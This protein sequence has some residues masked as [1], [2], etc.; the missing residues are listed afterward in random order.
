MQ[1]MRTT[2]TSFAGFLFRN[3]EG[4]RLWVGIAAV[5]TIIQVGS[6]LALAFPFKIILDKVVSHTNPTIPL[7]EGILSFFDQFGSTKNLQLGEVHT[8]LG[9]ILFSLCLLVI[10]S[11]INAVTTYIQNSIASIVGKNLTAELRKK[12]FDQLQ[13]L[14]LDWHNRQK[15]GDIVQRIIGDVAGIERLIT[16]GLIEFVSGVLTVIGITII[17]VLISLQ[18]TLL[19]VVVVPALFLIV[20]SYLKRITLAVRKAVVAA[21]EVSNVATED[22][23]AI[24]L[25]KGFTIED[26]ES[27]RFTRYVS[28]VRDDSVSAGELQAQI[29]PVVTF[30][31]SLATAVIIGVGIFVA[32]GNTFSLWF[33]T[34]PANAI[35]I[36]T[37]T[38]FLSYLAKLYTPI[39]SVSRLANLGIT[40]ATGAERIQEVFDQAPEVA[41]GPLAYNGPTRLKGDLQCQNVVFGYTPE[42]PVLKGIDFAIPAGSKIGIV[43]LSGGGKTTLI[44][45]FPRFYE[46]QQGSVMIDGLDNRLYPLNVVRQNISLVLQDSILFEGTLRENIALGRSDATDEEIMEAAKKAYIHNTIMMLPDGYSTRV[47][48]QGMNFSGGQ[49][50]RIAIARAIL[51]D[52]PILILDEPTASLDVEA[53]VEVT[54]ALDQLVVDR[55]VLVVSHRLS[56]LG[57]VDEIIVLKDGRIAERGT[58]QELKRLGGLFSGF[59]AEQNRYNVDR[60]ENESI[61]RPMKVRWAENG[62]EATVIKQLQVP[63]PAQTQQARLCVEVDGKDVGEYQLDKSKPVVTIGRLEMNDIVVPSRAVSRMH[64]RLRLNGDMWL[65]ED[66]ESLNGLMYSGDR[67]DQHALMNGD[68]ILL[69]PKAAV[70][71]VTA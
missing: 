41:D 15:K 53:E 62:H 48:E 65:I 69:A 52:A 6:D 14:T 26:R 45:L 1:M 3:L 58:F 30:L 46:V 37:L 16:D 68:R 44:K 13:R 67:V 55:T 47:R 59:L 18:F 50:Q 31:V 7:T 40:A 19:F 63:K 39:R 24:T 5:L 28:Q 56:T 12:L 35:T 8:Q 38:V 64:A 60:A 21:A 36:G 20:Y 33:F 17:I 9:I 32:T 2:T 22:V 27:M 57:N 54:R 49:R 61:V 23:A 25:I 70:R 71:Y 51:R 43:G 10:V 34:I 42:R 4:Q 66:T 29:T 11:F